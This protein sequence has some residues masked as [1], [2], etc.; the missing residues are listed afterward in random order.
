MSHVLVSPVSI[1]SSNE[2]DVFVEHSADTAFA[3]A[4]LRW[5]FVFVSP[6]RT[7]GQTMA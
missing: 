4:V 3:I 7:L 6:D 5:V 1:P 2:F